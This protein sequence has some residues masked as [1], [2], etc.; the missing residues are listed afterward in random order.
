MTEYRYAGFDPNNY[1]T[2]NGEKSAWRI[3]GL[4]NTPEGQRLK[5]ITT[6]NIGS[7]SWD[8]SASNING[9]R[10]VNE[11]SEADL[12]TL[13]NSGAY[14]NR[15][16]G[17]C[18]HDSNNTTVPCNFSGFGLTDSAKNMIDTITWNTGSIEESEISSNASKFY[19]IERGNKTGKGCSS[20]TFCTDTVTRTTTWKGQVGLIYPSDHSYATSGGPSTS[21]DV[22]LEQS[23]QLWITGNQDDCG[24]NDWINTHWTMTPVTTSRDNSFGLYLS[25][26]KNQPIL[27]NVKFPLYI[28]PVINLKTNVKI[29]SGTGTEENPYQLSIQ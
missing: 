23:Q 19:E 5:L 18:Y 21:R 2:F 16:S 11:W 10:G 27:T 22:C 8:S 29:I 7:Y 25:S 4:V 24:N 20:G 13:V 28:N 3:I 1:V 17:N 15:T 26:G 9:G 12:M 6:N 14:Y